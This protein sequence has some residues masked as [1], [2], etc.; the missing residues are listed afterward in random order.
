MSGRKQHQTPPAP[1][2]RRR[3]WLFVPAF[4]LIGAAAA[5]FARD[6][7]FRVDLAGFIRE[8]AGQKNNVLLI[9]IDTLRADRLHCYGFDE[10]STPNIDGLAESG[11][12]FTDATAHVPL[13]LPAHTAIMTGNF[14]SYHGV[15][16]NGGFYVAKSQITLAEMFKQNGFS[17]AAFVGAFVLD[18]TWGLNQGFDTYFDNFDLSKE[19]RIGLGSVQRNAE[20][21]YAHAVDWLDHHNK[22]R[23]FL[24]VHFYDPHTPYEPPEEYQK[25]YPNRPYVGEIAHTDAVVGKLLS[26]F[27][28]NGLRGHTVILLTG[29]HGESLGE[30]RES[31]HAF[32]VYDATLHVPM[33]LSAPLG[34]L[35]GKRIVQQ[36]R[37]VDIM[38]TLLQTAGINVPE[39][40]QG[41]SLLHLVLDSE[42]TELRPSYAECYYPQYH[43]GWSRLLSLRDGRF[44]YIDA[45]H[46]ELYDLRS[47]PR[48]T[49]NV[50]DENKDLARQMQAELRKIESVTSKEALMAPGD[51]DDE[52]HEKL[53]ALGY[54]GAFG[55]PKITDP[56]RLPDP[57]DKID[58]FNQITS[59]R[60]DSLDGKSDEAISKFKQVLASDPGI[61]D[62]HFMMGNEYFKT[63][64][65]PEALE[66]FK[67]ALELKPDYEFAMINMAN[68][69]RRMGKLEEALAGFE[70][71]LKKNPDNTQVLARIGELYLAKQEPDKALTYLNQALKENPDTSWVVNSIGVAYFQKKQ[72]KEAEAS[73]RKALQLNPK[74]NMAH[75]NL[76]QLFDLEKNME[77][78]QREYVLE[79]EVSPKNFK[80]AF[81]LGRIYVGQGKVDQG[82][83]QLENVIKLAPDFPLGYLFLAQARLEQGADL[84]KTEEL[85]QTAL[86]MKVDPEYRPLGHYILADVYNRQGKKD[87]EQKELRLAR[88]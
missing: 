82:I 81:N 45:P 75:F 79:L 49:R 4:L 40:V 7:L 85:A 62:A 23:F 47:D 13:T 43:F 21:V 77:A 15:H 53:A 55:G 70:Y 10:I 87:L 88:Q 32:F 35:K 9:T 56:S 48:E 65:Y 11:V 30:H 31:T 2:K 12:L 59:A 3:S 33:I 64:K 41:R 5:W 22:E 68:T 46:P 63:G 86:S 66:A 17:T 14:P 52:T 72:Y 73:F 69:Y 28:V 29:D 39:T 84:K 78:A 50:Y 67:K 24:W 16:D 57:K 54:V 19:E 83:A 80:A 25:L 74:I 51:V 76:A 44:K 34:E 36:V 1:A 71:F 37:S 58:L 27:D 6:K 38:P 26:Y 42:K 20:E 8:S 61:V 18:S 60:M